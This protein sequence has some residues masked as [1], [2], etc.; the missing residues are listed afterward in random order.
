MGRP[1]KE[2]PNHSSGMYEVKV[3]IGHDFNG[4]LIR[5]SFYSSISKPDAR[6]K[7]EEYKINQAVF[8]ATGEKAEPSIM[9]FETWANKWLETY[10]KGIVKE[11]TY[12]FTYKSILTNI[13]YPTLAKLIF[14][15]FSRLIFRSISI[16]SKA[17]QENRLLSPHLTSK[18]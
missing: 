15:Q 18:K 11:H 10:K 8:E 5:K 14:Q 12:N 16:Q 1:K 13:L 4:K 9:T 2:K 17:V 7:A 6:A 3:T